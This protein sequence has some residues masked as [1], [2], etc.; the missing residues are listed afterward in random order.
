MPSL[1][2][3]P[4]ISSLFKS[5][6]NIQYLRRSSSHLSGGGGCECVQVSTRQQ[7]FGNKKSN[8]F[9]LL[10]FLRKPIV[11]FLTVPFLAVNFQTQHINI[12]MKTLFSTF[13][14]LRN[15]VQAKDDR[16]ASMTGFSNQYSFSDKKAALIDIS[17]VSE[18]NSLSFMPETFSTCTSW[19]AQNAIWVSGL[20]R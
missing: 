14:Q 12:Y 1:W 16:Q 20:S 11:Y 10:F 6:E 4:F 3:L 8:I 9:H 17:A 18:Q 7:L 2:F 5:S 19:E 13:L 15:P